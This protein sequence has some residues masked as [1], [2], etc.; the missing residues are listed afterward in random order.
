MTATLDK[1]TESLPVDPAEDL[2]PED[3]GA[4]PD[5][6]LHIS[7]DRVYVL[8]DCPDPHTGMPGW[9][10]R[11]LDDFKGLEI[12]EYP[13]ADQLAQIL[14]ACCEPGQHLREQPIM[15]GAE[16]VPSEHGRL[17]WAR[18]YFAEGWEENEETGAVNFWEKQER[19]SVVVD[20]MMVRLHHPVEGTPGLNVFGIEI[21]VTKPDKV[22]LRAGKNVRTEE[23]EQGISYLATCNGRVRLVDGTISVDDVYL[24][25]GNVSLETGNIHHTGAV[26]I[27]GDVAA[28]AKIEADGDVMVKGMLEPCHIKC[29]GDLTV[30]GGIVSEK[31]YE[32][33]VAGSLM[34]RYISEATIKA[35]GDIIVTNEIAHSTL[36]CRGQVKVPKGRIAGGL[37]IARKGIRVG[38]AG[39]SGSSDTKLVAGVDYTLAVKING[40]EE[41]I[42]TLEEAQDKIQSALRS[43]MKSRD[44]SAEEI[45]T[46][47][48]LKR[49]NNQIAQ[50]IAD[51][52]TTIQKLKTDAAVAG[53]E[54]VVILK[55]LWSG[56][57][58]TLGNAKMVVRRSILKP[59]LAEKRRGKVKILP[60]GDG[61]MPDED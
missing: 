47:N 2:L 38:E 55:E 42:L 5:Y 23:D 24:I 46:I 21:P 22:K 28:G 30:G 39:S 54:E 48:K 45:K 61:N 11:I 56:T 44:P 31:E 59:R 41:K 9:I 40:Y 37:T 6:K 18:E 19:R 17:D 35:E 34:A 15:M 20:E 33:E 57:T 3:L 1:E 32:I 7:K 12:P 27:Q 13:D 10:T 49:K 8:L 43:G 36:M 14:T 50:A 29:G 52:H 4:A 58:I 51:I 53:R 25:K 16:A 26:V 60:L